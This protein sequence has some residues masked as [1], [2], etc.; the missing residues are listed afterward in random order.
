M[1]GTIW[2]PGPPIQRT[3]PL[4]CQPGMRLGSTSTTRA[5]PLLRGHGEAILCTSSPRTIA[6]T[7]ELPPILSCLVEEITIKRL[8]I[9]P[10]HTTWKM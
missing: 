5:T 10:E 1:S 8:S 2:S 6:Q 9:S 3:L 4:V 7:M